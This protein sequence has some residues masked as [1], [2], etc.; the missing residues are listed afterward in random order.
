MTFVALESRIAGLFSIA[1]DVL[2]LAQMMERQ[3]LDGFE[4]VFDNQGLYLDHRY[5][6]NWWNYYFQPID[7]GERK[8]NVVR[9]VGA[10]RLARKLEETISRREAFSLIR[11]YIQPREE[12][13]A[14]VDSFVEA[15][16]NGH[17][18]VGI[19]FR[20]TDKRVEAPVVRYEKVF[21]NIKDAMQNF[22]DQRYKIF[23]A[24]DEQG[25]LE[26]ALTE[27]GD[28]VCYNPEAFRSADGSP[29]HF[30]G[31]SP[32]HAGRQALVDCLL[33]SRTQYLVRTSSNLSRWSGYFNPNLD[34]LE[35][36]TR[37]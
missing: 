35:L 30:A 15:L 2:V 37:H 22:G 28:L 16:L 29:V 34:M 23:V 3:E 8:E 10:W 18:V 14:E 20:G 24:T 9:T 17:F 6:L 1:D 7:V 11:K 25:F 21:G 19:H 33:L 27:F 13:L 26:S 5:G 12:I 32:Y 4:V 31:H 36:S